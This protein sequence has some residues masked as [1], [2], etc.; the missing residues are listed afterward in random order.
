MNI[1]Q[2]TAATWNKIAG[3]YQE[4]FMPL[5]IYNDS[6]LLFCNGLRQ[7]AT[8]LE[9][10]CGPGNISKFILQTRP[11]LVLEAIDIAP[12]MIELAKQNVP[13]AK[14]KV[15]DIMHINT[16]DRKYDGIIAGFCFPYLMPREAQKLIEDCFTLLNNSSSLYLSFVEGDSSK[17]G[18]QTG[19]SGD[20]AYFNYYTL[21]QLENWLTASGFEKPEVIR[22]NYTKTAHTSEEHTILICKKM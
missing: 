1:Y 4:K 14:F 5:A 16:L 13:M 11:D 9:L 20:R 8:V 10:G 22:V 21:Q 15:M 7:G 17:S 18:F 3:V 2:E 19:S 6:Y 12:N